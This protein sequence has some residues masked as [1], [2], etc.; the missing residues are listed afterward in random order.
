MKEFYNYK[1]LF[2]KLSW[3]ILECKCYYYKFNNSIIDDFEYDMLEKEYDRLAEK[4]KLPKYTSEMVGFDETRHS[5][6]LV[7]QRAKNKLC[8]YIDY[9]QRSGFFKRVRLSKVVV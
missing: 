6:K 7:I 8:P 2:N 9:L 1:Q 4:L 5:S 3:A